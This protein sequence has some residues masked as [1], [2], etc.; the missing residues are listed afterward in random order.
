MV[1]QYAVKTENLSKAFGSGKKRFFAI[2]D[3]SLTIKRGEVFSLLGP[4]GAGKTTFLKVIATLVLPTY[5]KAFVNG[6]DI[7]KNDSKVRESIGFSTGFERSFYYRLSGYQNLLFF[8]SLYGIPGALLKRKI[9]FL[10]EEFGLL[11][12][13]NV[14]YMKYSTGMK[15]K[16]SII[17]ALLHD[18]PVYIFDEPMSSLDAETVIKVRNKI[19]ELKKQG[20][21]VIVAT[22]NIGEAEAISDSVSVMKQGKIVKTGS[23][24]T[25]KRL[26]GYKI[27]EFSVY[28]ISDT[29]SIKRELNANFGAIR[30]DTSDEKISCLVKNSI[31]LSFVAKYLESAGV[32]SA[33]II[34]KDPDLEKVFVS[35]LKDENSFAS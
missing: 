16:L 9:N 8:G 23:V 31:P 14:P 24:R 4:N 18:P 21:S 28:G 17:R 20:K 13:K 19:G 27:L 3:V 34:V 22:H 2:K 25:L 35:L 5:G 30:F 12:A 26:F 10:L 6:Y 32:P 1:T 29:E 15:K 33:S 11:K 7:L